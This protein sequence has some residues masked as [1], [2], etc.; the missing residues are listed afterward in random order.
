[1]NTGQLGRIIVDEFLRA[2]NHPFIC[3]IG[4]NA[5]AINPPQRTCSRCICGLHCKDDW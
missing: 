4:D 2:E 1:M 3:A 5:L